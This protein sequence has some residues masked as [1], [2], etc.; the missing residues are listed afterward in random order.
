MLELGGL[1]RSGQ[2][3]HACQRGRIAMSQCAPPGEGAV[4]LA[5]LLDADGAL[6]VRHPVVEPDLRIG[7]ELIGVAAVTTEIRK[8]HSVLA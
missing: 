5:K 8:G 6:Q 4:E 1:Q 3:R 2:V 7:L